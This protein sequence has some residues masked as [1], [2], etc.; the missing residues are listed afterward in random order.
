MVAS[1]IWQACADTFNT[2]TIAG[3]R[4]GVERGHE[5]YASCS[6]ESKTTFSLP[7]KTEAGT[8]QN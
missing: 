1:W 7:A 6:G 5:T 3:S 2:A 8:L 4:G